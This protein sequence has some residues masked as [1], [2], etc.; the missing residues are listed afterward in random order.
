MRNYS[1]N[2]QDFASDVINGIEV[3]TSAMANATY[4]I[5]TQQE[6]FN[7][8]GRIKVNILYGEVVTDASA[9]ATTLKFNFTS[10]TPVIG[11]ADMT[12]AS[13]SLSAAVPGTRVVCLG[14]AVATGALVDAGP[15]ISGA[16]LPMIIGTVDGIGTIGILTATASQASGTTKFVIDYVPLSDGAYVTA[17][18]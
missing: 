16:M 6:I 18:H 1:Q 2:T 8:Y 17:A 11:V 15:G 13:G 7:V 5:Q 9:N 10:T 3:E 14:T 4:M 12:A